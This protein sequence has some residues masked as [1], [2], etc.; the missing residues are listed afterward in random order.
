MTASFRSGRIA[1]SQMAS[2]VPRTQFGDIVVPAAR[3]KAGGTTGWKFAILEK[4]TK[5]TRTVEYLLTVKGGHVRVTIDRDDYQPFDEVP[6][7]PMLATIAVGTGEP[8]GGVYHE[9]FGRKSEYDLT[10]EPARLRVFADNYQFLVYD[11]ESE[12]FKPFPEMNEQ[13]S[14]TGLDSQPARFMDFHQGPRQ[15]SSNRRAARCSATILILLQRG[16]Q[17]T[18]FGFRPALWLCLNIPI[19]SSSRFLPVIT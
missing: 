16:R 5:K 18:T 2:D 7:E 17:F 4:N 3:F 12:P 8:L 14:R 11:F 13:T 1:G 9:F 19:T 6:I 15:R 10:K